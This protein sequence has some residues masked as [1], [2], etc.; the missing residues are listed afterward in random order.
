MHWLLLSC[1]AAGLL[2]VLHCCTSPKKLF[3]LSFPPLPGCSN[4]AQNALTGP[5]PAQWSSLSSLASL[6]ASSNY[7]SGPLPDSWRALDSLQELRLAS[8]NLGVGGRQ[9]NNGRCRSLSC[10]WYGMHEYR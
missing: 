2:L 1:S 5:L 9:A 7:L 10:R 3:R 8:N 6:D 4:L